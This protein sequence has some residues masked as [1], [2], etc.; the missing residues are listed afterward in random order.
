MDKIHF[1][2]ALD[3]TAKIIYFFRCST[4]TEHDDLVGGLLG[5]KSQTVESGK[6]LRAAFSETMIMGTPHYCDVTDKNGRAVQV[7]FDR[8]EFDSRP[9][10]STREVA[11]IAV[12]REVADV[13][14][15]SRKEQDVIPLIC[16]DKST[17]EIAAILGVSVS[18]VE[19]RRRNISKKLGVRGIGGI[20]R[21]AVQHGLD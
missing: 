15:L 18:T 9:E 16:Q 3:S 13:V 7:R 5:E 14:E 2:V 10:V 20:V 8:V 12:A 19:T 11:V 21:Y 1:V 6:R 17:S 4:A